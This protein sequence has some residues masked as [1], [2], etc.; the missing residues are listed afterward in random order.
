MKTRQEAGG[1]AGDRKQEASDR[2][3][4]NHGIEHLL[5]EDFIPGNG[6]GHLKL[7]RGIRLLGIID[8]FG[9][10]ALV[11]VGAENGN[12]LVHLQEERM[13]GIFG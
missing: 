10:E 13:L 11:E 7:V 3:Y 12:H 5:A 4:Q 9:T 8:L 1:E 6:T 2:T